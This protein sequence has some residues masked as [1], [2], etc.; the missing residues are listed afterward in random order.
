MSGHPDGQLGSSSNIGEPTLAPDQPISSPDQDY[1]G[2]GEFASRLARQLRDYRDDQCLVVAF[3]APWGAGKSSLLNLLASELARETETDARPPIVIRFNPWNFSGLPSLISIFFRELR[4]GMDLS[5]PKLAKRVRKSL[6]TLSAILAVGELSPMGGPLFGLASRLS[7]FFA[8]A[9][10]RGP[11]SIETVK[12]QINEALRQSYRRVFVFIDDLDRLDQESMRYMFRLIRLNADFDRVTY[13]LAFDRNV[14][15]SVL[16]MEQGVSGHEYLEKIVQ[17]GFDI[18]PAEPT[19]LRQIFL[20]AFE[21]LGLQAQNNEENSIRWVDLERAGFSKFLRT[22][23]DV[24][25]YTNGLAV[26]GAIV[27]DE[28]NP[29]DFAVIEAIRTF[30]PELHAFIRENRNVVIGPNGGIPN[31]GVAYAPDDRLQ[32]LEGAFSQCNPELRGALREVCNLLFPEI[33]ALSGDPPFWVGYHEEWRKG[34]RICTVEYFPR[35]FYLRPSDQD[36]SQAE[37]E[38]FIG[39]ARDHTKLAV[40][41]G[42]LIDSGKVYNFLQRLADSSTVLPEEHIESTVLALLDT[43]D[44]LTA[45]HQPEDQLLRAGR[46]VYKLLLRQE[47]PERLSTLRAVAKKTTSLG[48]VVDFVYFHSRSSDPEMELLDEEGWNEIRN[49]LVTRIKAASREMTLAQS[50]HLDTLLHRWREWGP[51]EDA[52]EFVCSLIKSDDGVLL[53]LQGMMERRSIS[54]EGYASLRGWYTPLDNVRGFIDPNV[55]TESVQRI[56]NERRNGMS[57]LQ[58]TAIDA[59]LAAVH[60]SSTGECC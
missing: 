16:T 47:G 36:V 24:V 22:P 19:K 44:D 55:L 9:I 17:V 21:S 29:V 27:A 48:A 57:D 42:E 54:I 56:Q 32:R 41:L 26:N 31:T 40:R 2:R 58:R 52:Q 15:E 30:A 53:F 20:K 14:V 46:V 34:I 1:L 3:Y 8:G 45:R 39:D 25:R 43:G 4:A 38:A 35:Y 11:G 33:R 5:E 37:F 50:P 6:H 12:R 10:G 28:V 23:R 60:S 13:V 59:F 18:P 7:K 51:I 49:D